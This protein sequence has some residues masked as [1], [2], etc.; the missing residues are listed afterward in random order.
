MKKN[1]MILLD[2]LHS[3]GAENLA[4]NIAVNLNKSTEYSPF[5]CVTRAGGVLEDK[6]RINNIKYVILNRNHRYEFYKFLPMKKIIR[7]ENIRIIHAHKLGSNFWGSLIG[8]F[9]GIPVISHFHTYHIS[10][11][12]STDIVAAKLIDRLSRKIISISDY[13]RDRLIS[14]EGITPSKIVTIH[15]G[16]DYSKYNTELRLDLKKEL[17]INIES[18]VVGIIAAFRPEKYHELFLLAAREIIKKHPHVIFLLVGDG[19]TRKKIEGIAVELGIKDNCVFTGIRQDIP[20]I[21]S[22]IDIGVLSSHWEGLPL[23]I[24]E[25]MASSK[26]VVSTNVSGLEEVIVNGENG[27]L[28]PPGD[29]R[30]LAEKI[31]MLIENETLAREMGKKAFSTV[32]EKFSEEI[33]MNKIERLYDEIYHTI[34]KI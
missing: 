25:Y 28:V 4:V 20:D 11:T 14:E 29:F 10:P 5:V 15:N 3:E 26:P 30:E 6:L 19:I 33:M 27:F 21:L 9:L 32:K 22:I 16:I 34:T 1:V 8:G 13:V 7:E 24:L 2:I 18:P 23:A 31:N 12:R 17:D